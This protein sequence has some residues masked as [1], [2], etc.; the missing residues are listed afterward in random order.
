MLQKI[1]TNL[2]NTRVDLDLDLVIKKECFA[3]LQCRLQSSVIQSQ[4]SHG[5]KLKV[6]LSPKASDYDRLYIVKLLKREEG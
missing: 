2:V 4:T 6:K 3:R 5:L 1:L